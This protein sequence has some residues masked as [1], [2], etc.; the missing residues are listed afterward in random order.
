[1]SK[2]NIQQASSLTGKSRATLYFD[3]KNGR[4]SFSSDD[5][6]KRFLDTE[7]LL[8]VYG[9]F[10]PAGV[11]QDV[12]PEHAKTMPDT[13]LDSDLVQLLK[14]QLAHERE[15]TRWL[16]DQLD[17]ALQRALPPAAPRPWWKIWR[18]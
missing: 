17:A 4:L 9:P 2:V 11:Q 7:E 12:Q 8:R 6:G 10:R 5:K 3:M 15:Q 1:M 18:R 13:A 14:E 16:R